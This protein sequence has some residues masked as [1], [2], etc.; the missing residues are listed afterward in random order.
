MSTADG[1]LTG[2]LILATSIWLGGLF[3]IAIV[4]RVA[5]RTLEPAARVAFFRGLGRAYAL[6]GT[7]ALVLAYGTGAALLRGHPWDLA[8]VAATVVA[9]V[10]AATLWVGM[11]Q[12]RRMTRLR[13]R[14]LDQPGDTALATRVLRGALRAQVLRGLIGALSL[15]LLALGVRI[16]A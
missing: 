1:V 15:S 9:V 7:A 14:A 8:K 3:A 10:L 5:T 12:A 4:A 2:L 11:A 16:A 6:V 13:R